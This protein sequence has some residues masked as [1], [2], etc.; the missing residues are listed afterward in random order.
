MK[1]AE[2]PDESISFTGHLIIE[3]RAQEVFNII[4]RVCDDVD[5]VDA[6]VAAKLIIDYFM[7]A[8]D[9]GKPGLDG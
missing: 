1:P 5:S 6:S 2:E 3:V 8:I 9:K 7:S 4:M